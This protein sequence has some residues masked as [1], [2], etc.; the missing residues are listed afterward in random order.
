MKNMAAVPSRNNFRSPEVVI[1]IIR[2]EKSKMIVALAY[3][4]VEIL[5]VK[6]TIEKNC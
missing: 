6:R 5:N 4:V 1:N 2:D 3:I